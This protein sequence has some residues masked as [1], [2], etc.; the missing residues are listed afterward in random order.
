MKIKIVCI[1]NQQPGHL[2]IGNIY[3]GEILTYVMCY[4][5]QKRRKFK[6]RLITL[7]EYH[8][9]S[10]IKMM[11]IS[12]DEPKSNG[13]NLTIG[14]VYEVLEPPGWYSFRYILYD[15]NDDATNYYWRK[16]LFMS[17]AQWREQ[18]INSILDY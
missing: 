17:I 11:C 14:K 16:E 1:K 7:A 5:G 15:K 12:N 9:M 2:T 10:W 6:K 18:Q 8:E 13:V 3:D 4:D